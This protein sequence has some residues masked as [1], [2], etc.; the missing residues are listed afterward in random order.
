M[1][2]LCPSAHVLIPYDYQTLANILC[3]LALFM[4]R[5]MDS[6][7]CMDRGPN[8]WIETLMSSLCQQ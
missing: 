2:S 5:I 1:S 4:V 3:T 7:C 8:E 6:L